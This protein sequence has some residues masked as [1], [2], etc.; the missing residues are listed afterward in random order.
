MMNKAWM[1]LLAA[2]VLVF[3]PPVIV[4]GQAGKGGSAAAVRR[5]AVKKLLVEKV[6]KAKRFAK[7]NRRKYRI[8][9]W[10]ADAEV[11]PLLLRI[12]D[13]FP[14][15]REAKWAIKLLLGR[16]DNKAVREYLAVHKCVMQRITATWAQLPRSLY[17]KAQP[18]RLGEFGWSQ[19]ACLRLGKR[20]T[21][22]WNEQDRRG[23]VLKGFIETVEIAHQPHRPAGQQYVIRVGY[24]I[25]PIRFHFK[26]VNVY[27]YGHTQVTS[28]SYL[29]D[30]V[31][32][33]GLSA[34]EGAPVA[35]FGHLRQNARGHYVREL[36][37]TEFHKNQSG[38]PSYRVLVY[39]WTP[40]FSATRMLTGAQILKAAKARPEAKVEVQVKKK[41][42]KTLVV[43]VAS[44]LNLAKNYLAAGMKK[45]AEAILREIIGKWPQSVEAAEAEELLDGLESE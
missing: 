39:T 11:R 25:H 24:S 10:R 21:L 14:D 35:L 7:A 18:R 40:R 6:R 45:E 1:A 16:S 37:G 8:P 3:W 30:K 23:V 22:I 43:R 29:G 38:Q 2:T 44:R 33:E 27:F 28:A 13:D 41:Q 9:V 32:A 5:S 20:L 34:L 31:R 15:S 26:G 19:D 12:V 17:P 4:R 36:D 42:P